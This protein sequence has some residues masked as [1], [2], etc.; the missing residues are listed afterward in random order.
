MTAS[1]H[2]RTTLPTTR[3]LIRVT[4][5]ALAALS[6]VVA[7]ASPSPARP[8]TATSPSAAPSTYGPPHPLSVSS[9]GADAV[10]RITSPGLACPDGPGAYRHY[11]LE[12]GVVAGAFSARPATLRGTL[13]VH[14]EAGPAGHAYLGSDASHVTV[15]DERGTLRFR[16]TGGDCA[17][18]SLSRNGPTAVAGAGAL[19][20]PVG[21]GAYRDATISGGTYQLAVD[22]APGADNQWSLQ[23]GGAVQV[24][25]P[26]L[27]VSVARTYWGNL[28][29]DYL[30]RRVTVVYRVTNSGDG[31]TF[32]AVFDSANA[33]PNRGVT[34]MPGTLPAPLGDLLAGESAEVAVRYQ[35][36][37]LAPCALVIL[38][39]NFST[40]AGVTFPDALDTPIGLSAATAVHAPDL[41]P[42]L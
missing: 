2:G 40:T 11:G 31:D 37:L 9:A 27:A 16:L 17:T 30:L 33:P 6:A 28:G 3:S 21:R 39:C 7:A 26:G 41:P 42:P 24:L 29:L 13:D 8:V 34:T 38:G 1:T 18:A 35:L 12:G 25:A 22:T 20:D 23:L 4:V 19:I 15:A 5:A 10:G 32:G 36:G 14:Y